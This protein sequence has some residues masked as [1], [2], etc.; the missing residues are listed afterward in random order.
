MKKVFEKIRELLQRK[1]VNHTVTAQKFSEH[2][3][4]D[5]ATNEDNIVK[6][7]DEAIEIVNRV[8]AEFAVGSNDGWIPCK[9]KM[10]PEHDSILKKLKGTRAWKV[11]MYEKESDWVMAT[12]K[13]EDGKKSVKTLYTT[14]GQWKPEVVKCKV[15]AWRPLPNPY[16]EENEV[17]LAETNM[18][19]IR[20][21]SEEELAEVLMCPYDSAGNLF[22]EIPCYD[23]RKLVTKEECRKCCVNWLKSEVK[24]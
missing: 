13:Y 20:R 6:G 12:I 19:R 22:D 4:S 11:P 23:G 9:V 18:D 1:S 14:D 17:E 3:F 2:G 15:I 5:Y 21:M 7:L 8:E 24:E 16:R 10:P